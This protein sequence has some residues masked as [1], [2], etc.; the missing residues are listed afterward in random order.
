MCELC[1]GKGSYIVRDMTHVKRV[2]CMCLKDSKQEDVAT[3]VKKR[4]R[5]KRELE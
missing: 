4:G 5:K 3:E 1:N 2:A